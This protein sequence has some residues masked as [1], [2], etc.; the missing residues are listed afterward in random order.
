MLM[1]LALKLEAVLGDV[2]SGLPLARWWVF[3]QTDHGAPDRQRQLDITLA[4]K[5]SDANTR[6]ELHADLATM[7]FNLWMAADTGRKSGGGLDIW[8]T[9]VDDTQHASQHNKLDWSVGE[10]AKMHSSPK[11]R[12]GYG[13]NKAGLF[14]SDYFHRTEDSGFL[15]GFSNRRTNVAMLWGLKQKAGTRLSGIG[16]LS[17]AGRRKARLIGTKTAQFHLGTR[18]CTD[19]S[20]HTRPTPSGTPRSSARTPKTPQA[21]P[22]CFPMPARRP[23]RRGGCV[24]PCA[25]GVACLGL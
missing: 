23:P 13:Y 22:R 10:L 1:R 15:P 12:V 11:T 5:G 14:L 7:G 25:S 4:E 24:V 9:I 3:K 17:S 19:P 8:R 21:R 20:A 6:V 18:T 16:R 2:F